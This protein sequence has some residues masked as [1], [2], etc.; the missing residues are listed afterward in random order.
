MALISPIMAFISQVMT[1]ISAIISGITF[2][3]GSW[4]YKKLF[5][6]PGI[7]A[8]TNVAKRRSSSH[9]RQITRPRSISDPFQLQFSPSQLQDLMLHA[10]KT[11]PILSEIKKVP[12]PEEIS[13]SRKPSS[14]RSR[15]QS[16][17]DTPD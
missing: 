1:L 7:G 16:I 13:L 14:R 10:S 12:L 9:A 15:T 3:S 8:S 11:K 6:N 4:H 17:G 5:F 2:T